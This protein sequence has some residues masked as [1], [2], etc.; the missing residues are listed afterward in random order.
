MKAVFVLRSWESKRLIAKGIAALP[1]VK[2]ALKSGGI[3]VARGSTN[4]YVAEE[5]LGEKLDKGRYMA[6]LIYQGRLQ[7][8]PQALWLPMV[9][10]KD[11]KRV[12]ITFEEALQGLG[13]D[14]VFIKG[15]NALDPQGNVG[16]LT[17]APDG[18]TIGK[19]LGIVTA[20]GAHYI[21]PIGLEKLVPSVI[22][23]S[24]LL[25][26]TTVDYATGDK[27]GLMPISN[28]KVITEIEALRILFGLEAVHVASGGVGD[29]CGSVVLSCSG[30]E[31]DVNR[32]I[33]LIEGIKKEGPLQIPTF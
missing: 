15:G 24:K 28:A 18:G 11:G 4:A 33:K 7:V 27:V 9:I 12:D 30:G 6:G 20:R 21:A 17:A 1:E 3:I 5:L 10:L 23:A 32:A 13:K 31:A 8:L 16:I 22:E 14:D 25:G 2:Q 19:A 29:S 26:I